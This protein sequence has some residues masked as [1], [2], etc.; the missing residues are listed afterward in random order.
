MQ[1]KF[2][3]SPYHFQDMSQFELGN[4]LMLW[5]NHIY[6]EGLERLRLILYP[7]LPWA[8]LKTFTTPSAMY[9]KLASLE[10]YSANGRALQIF[11][12]ALESIGGSER[13]KY[14]AKEA[15]R[16]LEFNL[17]LDFGGE[18]KQ[19][20]FFFWLLKIVRCLPGEC[21]EDILPHFGRSLNKNYRHFEGSLTRLFIELH[22]GGKLHEDDT[23]ELEGLLKACKFRFPE[24]TPE[25]TA[26]QKCISILANF[27][28]GKEGEPFTSGIVA[29]KS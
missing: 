26:V 10:E 28:N 13:G 7:L 27:H 2:S 14:C 9:T 22:Q 21:K 15:R 3:L 5:E 29:Y 11:L 12:F 1:C 16:I 8:E 18:P 24:S 25:F 19:F 20:R 6:G 23:K 4:V 17:H